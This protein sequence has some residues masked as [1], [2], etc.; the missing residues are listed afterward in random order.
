[1]DKILN[2]LTAIMHD[3]SKVKTN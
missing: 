1:M 2:S 3:V